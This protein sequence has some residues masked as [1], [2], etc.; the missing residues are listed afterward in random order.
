MLSGQELGR[1]FVLCQGSIGKKRKVPFAFTALPCYF[2]IEVIARFTNTFFPRWLGLNKRKKQHSDTGDHRR[3]GG[4]GREV[5]KGIKGLNGGERRLNV[6]CAHTENIHMMYC[7][8]I[9]LKLTKFYSPTFPNKFSKN[10]K[11]KMMLSKKRCCSIFPYC[12]E[13]HSLLWSYICYQFLNCSSQRNRGKLQENLFSL[14]CWR[15]PVLL[16]LLHLFHVVPDPRC[17]VCTYFHFWGS[18]EKRFGLCSLHNDMGKAFHDRICWAPDT[19][20]VPTWLIGILA[21]QHQASM[22]ASVFL[23]VKWG[24]K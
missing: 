5:G 16:S 13:A 8:T 18:F 17:S 9:H 14:Y 12:T 7:R 21:V 11:N 2:F 1:K 6:G 22:Q 23:S 20:V 10:V 24:S 4:W 19:G 15:R 3:E